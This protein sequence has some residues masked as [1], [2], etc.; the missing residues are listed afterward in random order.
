MPSRLPLNTLPVFRVVAE[1]QNLR[2]AGERLHLT[3][4]AISQQIRHLEEQLGFALFDRQGRRLRLNAAGAALLRGVTPALAQLDESALAAAAAA[5]EGALRLR[6]SVLPSFAQR[7]LLPRMAR[8]R[9]RHPDISLEIEASQ[10]LV[11]LQRED[12]HAALRYGEGL[13][14]GVVSEPLF[15]VPMRLVVVASPA[16]ARRLAGAAPAR[17]VTE[18]LL[19]ERAL[20]EA[21][22]Q[23][24]GV[25][26][27]VTPVA[28][29]NDAGLLLQA[30]EQ[31]LGLALAREL[32]AA[33]ALRDG[34]LLRL[35]PM[36]IPYEE[37]YTYHLVCRPA[38]QDW[39]P[40]A[41]LR[42]WLREEIALARAELAANAGKPAQKKG[43]SGP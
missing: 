33:D 4:S 43:P 8:W 29:F 7:W 24:C 2:A 25:A 3:H 30:A 26:A 27:R 18:P 23:A 34:R 32:L 36:S 16:T 42:L 5:Q 11:D 37:R 35:F 39:P 28:V 21:W 41:A 12:F 14:P 38:L 10:N 19:G 31:G 6:V 9:Q 13:W 40:L 17:I 15:Q 1:L 22:F 20:W